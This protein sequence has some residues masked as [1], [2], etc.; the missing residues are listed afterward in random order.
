[1]DLGYIP[2]VPVRDGFVIFIDRI[3]GLFLRF[4]LA[5]GIIVAT[6]I[7]LHSIRTTLHM[8]HTKRLCD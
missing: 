2:E 4:C 6:R 3:A 1:M 5:F 8:I 7:S